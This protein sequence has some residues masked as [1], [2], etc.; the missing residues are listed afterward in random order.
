LFAR[1]Y[2]SADLGLIAYETPSEEG[3]VVEEEVLLEIVRPG[4]GNPVAEGEVGEVVVTSFQSGLPADSLCYRRSFGFSAGD[5]PLW[6]DQCAHQGLAGARG[7]DDQGQGDVRTPFAGRG[8]LLRGMAKLAARGWW[9]TM[10][11]VRIE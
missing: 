8:A 2:A 1:A 10:P 4:T 3:L 11:A 6:Q 5:Q 7:S 9:S